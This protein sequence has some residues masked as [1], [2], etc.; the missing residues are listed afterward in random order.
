MQFALNWSPEASA[1]LAEG[2][3]EIDLF[4]CPDWQ[5]LV[6]DARRQHPAYIHFPLSIGNGETAKWDFNEIERWLSSTETTYVNCHIAPRDS[7]FPRDIAVDDLTEA[8]LPEVQQLV[9]HFG[10][11]RVIIENC[12]VPPH[13]LKRG[14]LIQGTAP[15]LLTQL[16]HDTG[17]GLLM[18]VS[19]AVLTSTQTQGDPFEYLNALPTAHIRELHITG[20]GTWT[21]GDQGD[22]MPMTDAD[23]A[24]FE[25]C[26]AQIESGK[27]ATP[28]V[29]AF[30]YGGIARLK[31]L[32]GSDRDA[33]AEQ[34]PRLYA[35]SKQFVTGI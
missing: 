24:R 9:R 10:A 1:L 4:K 28:T 11:E 18:D 31:E 20:I 21:N 34:V 16:V 3:I 5:D 7:Q 14:Y 2:L 35:A 15:Q 6:D 27:W 19:H 33:I 29:M 32:C 26:M 30:E 25:W 23:W 8:L 12:P 13:N 17:C 22:H